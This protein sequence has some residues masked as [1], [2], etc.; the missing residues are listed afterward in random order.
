[1]SFEGDTDSCTGLR[2]HMLSLL[3]YH[4]FFHCRTDD[5]AELDFTKEEEFIANEKELNFINRELVNL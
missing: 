5:F 1:M 2:G 4:E 3:S